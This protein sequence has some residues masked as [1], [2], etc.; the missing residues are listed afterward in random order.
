M[1]ASLP[2]TKT[3]LESGIGGGTVRRTGVQY[4]QFPLD[5][6]CSAIRDG[7]AALRTKRATDGTEACM[8]PQI[9]VEIK[10]IPTN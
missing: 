3:L 10:L 2:T 1:W 4:Q 8:R 7:S 9:Q 5:V 6:R